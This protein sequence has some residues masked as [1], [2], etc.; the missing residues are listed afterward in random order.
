MKR[1]TAASAVVLHEA[2]PANARTDELDALVQ[3]EQVSIALERLGWNV[4]TLATDLDLGKTLKELRR[5]PPDCVFNLVESLDGNGRLIHL[6]PS[7]LS[8]AGIAYSGCDAEAIFLTSQKL[9]A[10]R[11]MA[12]HGVP[13]PAWLSSGESIRQDRKPWI[14]KSVW[15]HASLGLDDDSVVHGKQALQRRLDE[16]KS[17][18]GGEWFAERFIAGREFNISLIE[19]SGEPRILPIAEINFEGYPSDK[20]KI[21]GYAAKWDVA[22]I[23]YH[24]TP[25]SFPRLSDAQDE[26][27]QAIARKC[28]KIF[29]LHGYA[30]VDIRMDEQGVAWVLE[31]N[32]N[33]CLSHDAGYAAAAT[34][35][36]MSYERLV[37][38]IMDAALQND[39]NQVERVV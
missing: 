2:L 36:R 25:R 16:C 15:E 12:L 38:T 8:A 39:N 26:R 9:V 5:R 33:P 27:L 3:V 30:R 24:N 14:V 7:L 35:A 19:E 11:W 13:T 1:Q 32:T 31:I 29:G 20:P 18:H 10:K 37:E 21:V 23:E 6:V 17:A 28:W 22:A 4:S 34:E